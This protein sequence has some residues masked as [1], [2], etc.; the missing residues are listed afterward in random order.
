LFNVR[1]PSTAEVQEVGLSV[2]GLLDC[3]SHLH[4]SLGI[5]DLSAAIQGTETNDPLQTVGEKN[6]MQG[7][8][9]SVIRGEV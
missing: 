7:C 8:S 4:S 2:A 1:T 9:K 5:C 3:I 6:G